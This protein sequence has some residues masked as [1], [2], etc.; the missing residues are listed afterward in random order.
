[1]PQVDYDHD[2]EFS[3]PSTGMSQTLA[4]VKHFAKQRKLKFKEQIEAKL[5]EEAWKNREEQ[6]RNFFFENLFFGSLRDLSPLP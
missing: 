5:G 2:H 4:N 1:M 6:E 3:S